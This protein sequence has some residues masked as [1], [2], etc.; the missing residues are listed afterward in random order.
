MTLSPPWV[1]WVNELKSLFAQDKEVK[2]VADL[3]EMTVRVYVESEEKADAIAALLPETKE[4]GN[5]TLSV[6]VVPGNKTGDKFRDRFMTAFAGNPLYVETVGA[7]CPLGVFTY[8]LWKADVVQFFND[9]LGDVC[10]NKSM[11]PE[12]VAKDVLK[13]QDGVY[14][15]TEPLAVQLPEWP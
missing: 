1:T 9:N 6:A 12:T 14:H 2:V 11:L 5:V 10:G 3:E 7:E 4:F 15:C 13:A 8:V